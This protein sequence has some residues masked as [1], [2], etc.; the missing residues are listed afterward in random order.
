MPNVPSP[1][2]ASYLQVAVLSSSSAMAVQASPTEAAQISRIITHMNT[3]HARSLSL[4]LRHYCNLPASQT[5]TATLEDITLDHLILTTAV[6]TKGRYLIPFTPPLASLASAR[7]RLVAMHTASLSAL[8]LD[9]VVVTEYL[10]PTKLWEW[11]AGVAV[12]LIFTTFPFRAKLHPDSHSWISLIWS[13][14]GLVEWN[15]RLTYYIQPWLLPVV[16]AIHV[17]EVVVLMLPRLRRCGVEV[18]TGVWWAWVVDCFLEGGG[19][20]LRFDGLVEEKRGVKGGVKALGG[21]AKVEG[22]H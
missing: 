21:K 20:W 1:I 4:Y 9:E 5:T 15:A 2:D 7:E 6:P 22:G 12:F 8:D 11:F 10:Y 18:G 16:L 14:G 3:D 19:A 17:G 13:L